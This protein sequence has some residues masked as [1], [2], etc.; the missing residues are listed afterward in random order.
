MNEETVIAVGFAILAA[1]IAKVR[2]PQFFPT[3]RTAI[4]MNGHIVVEHPGAVP[5]L[6]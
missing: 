6:G 1:F 2:L 4:N 5:R 3:S